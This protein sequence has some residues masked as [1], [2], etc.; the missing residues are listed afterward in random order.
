[1]FFFLFAE[2]LLS[3]C[4]H[5]GIS[6]LGG[7]WDP[8]EQPTRLAVGTGPV[9]ALLT[10]DE[11]LWASCANQVTVL[12]ATGLC[13]QVGTITGTPPCCIHG[14]GGHVVVAFGGGSYSGLSPKGCMCTGT[15]LPVQCPNQPFIA[16]FCCFSSLLGPFP[17]TLGHRTRTPRHLLQLHKQG[18]LNSCFFL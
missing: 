13:A 2:H 3:A 9:R 10:L 11:T 7:L 14:T 15:S 5:H 16:A 18:M 6:A 12:D 8:T 4:P 17:P 1:M